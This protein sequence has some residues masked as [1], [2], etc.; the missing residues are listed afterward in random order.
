MGRFVKKFKWA[1]IFSMLIMLILSIFI[2]IT[3]VPTPNKISLP[4]VNNRAEGTSK[5]KPAKGEIKKSQDDWVPIMRVRM[6]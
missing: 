2:N 1:L 4:G 6:R 3:F 5:V